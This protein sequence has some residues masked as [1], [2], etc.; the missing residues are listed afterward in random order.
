M[1]ARQYTIATDSKLCNISLGLMSHCSTHHCCWCDITKENL[2]NNGVSRTIK[3]LMD[4]FCTFF[5]ARAAGKDAKNYGNIIYTNMFAGGNI[6][7]LTPVI[8]LIY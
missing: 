5:E 7:E 8:L 6:Y 2:G 3:S 4:L 1:V